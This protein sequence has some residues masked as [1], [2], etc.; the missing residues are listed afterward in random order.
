MGKVDCGTLCGRALA[1]E[2]I[3]KAFT[4]CGGHNM[5][6]LYGIRAAGIE[7]IDVRHEASAMFAAIAYAQ[8]AGKPA[9]VITTAGPGVTNTTS[10]MLEAMEGGVPIIHIGAAVVSTMVDSGPLQDMS[11]LPVMES[12]SKWARKIVQGHRIP[13]YVSLA[14]RQAMDASPGPVYLEVPMDLPLQEVDE[15]QVVMPMKSRATIPSWG[16]ATLIEEAAGLLVNA[17]QPAIIVDR[18]ARYTIDG[19]ADA[20]ASISDYL[21]APLAV[22]SSACRGLFGDES[23]NRLLGQSLRGMRPV[24]QADVVLAIGCQFDWHINQGWGIRK[25]ARVIQ[26]NTN[27]KHIGYNVH[28]DVGIVGGAGPVAAQLLAAI[29][30][31]RTNAASESWMKESNLGVASLPEKYHS[32]NIPIHPARC[33]VEAGKFLE[34]EGQ[35]WNVVYDGGDS[36]IWIRDTTRATR[37]AQF[38][39]DSPT[40]CVGIGAASVIGLWSVNRKPVL[41]YT[42]DGSF[43]FYSME[44]DTMARMGIPVVCVISN[45]SGWGMIR[46]YQDA[47]PLWKKEVEKNGTCA[48]ELEH[49]RAYEKMVAMWDGYG[50]MV[51]DPAEIVPAIRRA[52]ANGKPSIINVE[53]DKVSSYIDFSAMAG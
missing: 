48:V 50:E 38:Y 28:V 49:M 22:A 5:S 34:D 40:G 26:V 33:A 41:W 3:E 44:M 46:Y 42:G 47:E 23:K 4:L 32:E 53:V 8:A 27:M 14:F 20:I 15:E 30:S 19:Y 11:T 12:C 9:A 10:G 37:P 2:G 31:R 16:D 36:S 24:S 6:I 29:K 52:A 25:D 43:G 39:G 1:N 35:D 45:D 17:E 51:T 21:K 13:E 18:G 7:L